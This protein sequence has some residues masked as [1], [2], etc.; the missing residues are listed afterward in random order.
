MPNFPRFRM[1][2]IGNFE[3]DKNFFFWGGKIRLFFLNS[4]F[5]LS[6]GKKKIEY[7]KIILF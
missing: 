1:I 2:F 5:F 4:I 7:G 6:G 3:E